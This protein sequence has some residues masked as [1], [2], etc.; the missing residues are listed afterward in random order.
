[1]L[2]NNVRMHRINVKIRIRVNALITVTNWSNELC[3]FVV[4]VVV[5]VYKHC[6]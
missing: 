5:V 4:A 6:K 1:M 2:E 3:D